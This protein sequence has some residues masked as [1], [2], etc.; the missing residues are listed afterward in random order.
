MIRFRVL[1]TWT[2]EILKY[3]DYIQQIDTDITIVRADFDPFVKTQELDAILGFYHC[4]V[5]R[6]CANGLHEWIQEYA[7]QKGLKWRFL[8]NVY[9][10]LVYSVNFATLNTGFFM[11]NPVLMQLLRDYADTGF[12]E[13]R[14]W[15]EQVLYPYILALFTDYDRVYVYGSHIA[16]THYRNTYPPQLK[17]IKKMF[18]CCN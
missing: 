7:K 11:N 9:S 10:E 6:T 18:F 17:C 8:E 15:T 1:G 12:I 13:T 14:R 5:D 4:E 16:L 3:F 2:Q